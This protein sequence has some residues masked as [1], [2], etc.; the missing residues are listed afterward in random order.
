LGQPLVVRCGDVVNILDR[1]RQHL[2]IDALW[3]HEE[4]GN[5]WTYQRDKRVAAWAKQHGIPWTEIP[6]F[7]VT[8]RLKSR[9]L[10]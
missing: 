7:G 5:G 6:Q 9:N 8:R 4:T 10:V 1:A 3:S 2:G